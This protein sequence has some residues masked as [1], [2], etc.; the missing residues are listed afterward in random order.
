MEETGERKAVGEGSGLEFKLHPLVII[1]ISDHFT[2]CSL[3]VT[4]GGRVIGCLLGEQKGRVIHI[5]NTFE[6]NFKKDTEDQSLDK[7]YLAA[8]KEQY[9]TVFPN[10][11]VMGWYSTGD[12]IQESDMQTHKTISEINESPVFLLLDPKM[13]DERRDLP[14]MIYETELHV[15]ERF[16]SQI[17]V[18]AKYTVDSLEAERIAVDQV[19]RIVPSGKSSSTEQLSSHM[20]GMQNAVKMLRSRIAVILDTVKQMRDGKIACDQEL[21]RE[22][23]SLV[24]RLP[25]GTK[26]IKDTL[27]TEYNDT[28]MMAYLS[29][30]TK[31]NAALHEIVSKINATYD[32]K[33][34]HHR[35]NF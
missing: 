24:R 15:I 25:V 2:R 13:S 17:F 18:Q 27:N 28:L 34:A 8:K 32:T 4:S 12:K 30:M 23:S 11:E 26:K 7:E 9:K 29:F 5:T 22:I 20:T 21:L 19:A 31:G 14:I 33:V 16:P 35:R 6:M 10:L 3:N 1:N